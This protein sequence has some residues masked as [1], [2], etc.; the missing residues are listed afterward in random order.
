MSKIKSKLKSLGKKKAIWEDGYFTG[1]RIARKEMFKWLQINLYD[2][3]ELGHE[4]S[5]YIKWEELK[6]SLEDKK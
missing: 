3:I 1:Y 2:F 5:F 6:Q 4:H